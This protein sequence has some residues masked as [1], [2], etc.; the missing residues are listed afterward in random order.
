MDSEVA[1]RGERVG[2]LIHDRDD[3][4]S[5]AT[6]EGRDQIGRSRIVRKLENDHARRRATIARC[7]AELRT[8]ELRT[9][10][11]RTAELRT[12][13]RRPAELRTAALRTAELGPVVLGPAQ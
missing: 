9:A 5:G 8:A 13:E 3:R 2:Q 12:D 10:E 7:A 4:S 6:H 1:P 11:L